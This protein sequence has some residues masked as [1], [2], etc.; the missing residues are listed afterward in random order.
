[1]F[2]SSEGE[3]A[4]DA[5]TVRAFTAA[6]ASGVGPSDDA[7]RVDLIRAIEE[8]KCA[9]EGRQ[10]F[11]AVELDASQRAEQAAAGER[12]ER[13]GRGVAAQVAL[14]RRVSTNRGQRLLALAKVV[15]EMPHTMAAFRVGRISEWRVTIL[16]RETA[17]LER[18]E[19]AV[20]DAELASDVGRLEG[21]GDK[22]LQGAAASLAARLDPASVARRRRKAEEERSVTIRPAPDTMTYVTALLPVAQGVAVHAALTREAATKRAAGDPRTQGQVMADSFVERVTGQASASRGPGR[23]HGRAQR[24]RTAHWCRRRRPHRTRWRAVVVRSRPSWPV[25]WCWPASPRRR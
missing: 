22:Q 19:R 12:R 16:L 11:E 10:A 3:V 2:E 7:G 5:D 25:S 1:M 18:E 17:M 4:V 20:V 8:L 23:C 24:Q 14:A 9:G 6:L 13:Q 15:P 21:M